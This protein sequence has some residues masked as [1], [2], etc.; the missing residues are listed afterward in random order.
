MIQYRAKCVCHIAI[1]LKWK[2]SIQKVVIR[3]TA[4]PVSKLI[5]RL[6]EFYFP[7]IFPVNVI[8]VPRHWDKTNRVDY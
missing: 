2:R 4:G 5:E 6:F 3:F 7:E 8:L 1:W